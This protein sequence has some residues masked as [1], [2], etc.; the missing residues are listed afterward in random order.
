MRSGAAPSSRSFGAFVAAEYPFFVG[1]A[2][3]AIL[4]ALGSEV[5]ENVAHP[6]VLT[7]TLI[8]LL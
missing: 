8:V 6:L 7:G 3:A 2:I 4:L 1:I 5:L